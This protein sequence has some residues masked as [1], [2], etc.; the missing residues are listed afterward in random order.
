LSS[1]LL[2]L[3][4]VSLTPN[5]P[6]KVIPI[7]LPSVQGKFI[8]KKGAYMSA[9]D[10]VKIAADFD[11]NPINVCCGGL[12]CIRQ[13]ASGTGTVFYAAGGTILQKTL[14][15]GET[16]ITDALSIVGFQESVKFGV[17]PSGGCG[18]MCCGGEGLCYG[19]LTGPGVI[20]IQSMPF[21]K[22]VAAVSPPAQGG[23]AG[24]DGEMSG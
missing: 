22:F 4:F 13:E 11:C 23:A 2:F 7:H 6:A 5:F 24:G 20:L 14:A 18:G 16:V 9:I 1:Y 17:R 19:T 8:A 15:P 10:D 3:R 12:G 21:E